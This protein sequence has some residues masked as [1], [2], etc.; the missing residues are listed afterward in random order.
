[1][2][3][4]HT[5]PQGL[6]SLTQ[7]VVKNAGNNLFM[8]SPKVTEVILQFMNNEA[9]ETTEIEFQLPDFVK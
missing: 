4:A 1:L 5:Q 6:T 8:V 9:V 3:Y 2:G 7:V